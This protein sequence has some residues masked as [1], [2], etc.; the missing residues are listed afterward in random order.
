MA[1]EKFCH[2]C[3]E[4]LEYDHGK[5]LENGVSVAMNLPDITPGPVHYCYECIPLPDT[6]QELIDL[7]DSF[8]NP[9]KERG[10]E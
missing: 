1:S 5:R 3:G 9:P 8:I 4:P 2:D 6:A 10:Y 7:F